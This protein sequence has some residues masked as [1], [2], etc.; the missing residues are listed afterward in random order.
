[1][2]L[3]ATEIVVLGLSYLL[4]AVPVGGIVLVG[5][6]SPLYRLPRRDLYRWWSWCALLMTGCLLVRTLA[7]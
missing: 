6:M 5:R 4:S 7:G 3:L 2:R 1:M